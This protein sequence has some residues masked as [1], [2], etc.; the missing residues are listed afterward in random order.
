LFLY[1]D[2]ILA[3]DGSSGRPLQLGY[4]WVIFV[5]VNRSYC[6]KFFTPWVR[7]EIIFKTKW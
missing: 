6:T 3:L 2:V 1:V 5:S 7:G 4:R